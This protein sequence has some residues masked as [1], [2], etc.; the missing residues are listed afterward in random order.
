MAIE[1]LANMRN[2][3]TCTKRLTRKAVTA[4]GHDVP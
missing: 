3:T 2:A 1:S 4:L